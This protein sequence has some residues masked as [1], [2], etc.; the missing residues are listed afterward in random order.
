MTVTKIFTSEG[1]VADVTGV[2]YNFIG[3]VK[4][5]S[6]QYADEAEVRQSIATL[7]EVSNELELK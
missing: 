2:G 6:T 4:M 5:R 3:D 7:L 1:C